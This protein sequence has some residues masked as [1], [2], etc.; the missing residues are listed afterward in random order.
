MRP[1]KSRARV[2]GSRSASQQGAASRSFL[3]RGAP[4]DIAAGLFVALESKATRLFGRLEHAVERAEA[5]IRFVEA[6][7]HALDGLLDHRSPDLVVAAPLGYQRLDGADDDVDRFLLTT[8]IGLLRFR[9][10]RLRRA[11]VP[12][13]G[14]A[15]KRF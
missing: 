12:G 3:V 5:V 15:G 10:R 2:Q 1:R 9:L 6:G 13:L 4:H 11:R 7:T 8:G 14:V